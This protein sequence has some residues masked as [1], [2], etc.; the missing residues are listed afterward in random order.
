MFGMM[1]AIAACFAALP[2]GY[3]YDDPVPTDLY[4]DLN[5]QTAGFGGN[6]GNGVWNQVTANWNIS[7]SGNDTPRFWGNFGPEFLVPTSAFFVSNGGEVT[8]G[9]D[10]IANRINVQGSGYS[11]LV[12]STTR[13]VQGD[14]ALGFAPTT[15]VTTSFVAA[16]G[17]DRELTINRVRTTENAP[18]GALTL[19]TNDNFFRVNLSSYQVTDNPVIQGTIS[20]PITITGTGNVNLV[21]TSTATISGAINGNGNTLHLGATFGNSLTLNGAINNGDGST[22]RFGVGTSTEDGGTVVLG[23]GPKSW[24]NTVIDLGGTGVVRLNGANALPAD[25]SVSFDSSS[26]L[27]LNGFNLTVASLSSVNGVVGTVQNGSAGAESTLT[28]AGSQTTTFGGI[29]ADGSSEKLN[30]VRSGTGTTILT[31]NNTFSGTTRVT[32]GSLV[33]EGSL[34]GGGAVSVEGGNL[35][36]TNTVI[37]SAVDVSNGANMV[38]NGFIG[39]GTTSVAGSVSG[40]G[41]IESASGVTI[42]AGGTLAP[43]NSIGTLF[44]TGDLSFT[45]G[46]FFELEIDQDQLIADSLAVNG[47]LNLDNATLNITD[48]GAVNNVTIDNTLFTIATFTS[49]TGTFN[50]LANNDIVTVGDNQWRISYGGSAITLSAVPEPSALLF[51]GSMVGVALVRRRRR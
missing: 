39:T 47:A 44:V 34:A 3:A 36:V 40:T 46:S 11:F 7:P 6:T 9:D 1:L 22:V 14:W 26:T 29:L 10:V 19:A 15:P 35:I 43:G 28:I 4:W 45:Q 20:V 8:F 50:G 27:Q 12:N 51:V 37:S 23:N 5:G 49:L 18:A 25:T 2:H 24:S 17:G 48:L 31:E 38:V 32:G 41:T 21:G 33:I 16:A 42:A 13:S 30:L